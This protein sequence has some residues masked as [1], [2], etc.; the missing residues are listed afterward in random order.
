M[1]YRKKQ[2]II[3]AI[4]FH[5][6]FVEIEKFVGS[7]AEFNNGELT[8][9]TLEGPL[10][11][12]KYDWI[13]KGV[14][15]EFYPCKPDIFECTYEE[16]NREASMTFGD[17]IKALKD[18]K[19]V[20]RS[21]WNGKG[22]FIYLVDGSHVDRKLLRNGIERHPIFDA[23]CMV[24]FNSHIDMRTA[25]GSVCIGWLAS[26]SDMLSEDWVIVD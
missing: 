24:H 12:S 8:V 10:H 19:R 13:I 3:D 7:D 15:G 23:D 2:I 17:A 4:Q 21:G 14:K 20:A 25:D 11:A 26:Q 5:G 6:N 9:A 18:G 16:V 1:K 22:M